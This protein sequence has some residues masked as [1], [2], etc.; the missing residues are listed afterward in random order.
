M[1]NLCLSH[2]YMV[3]VII[4]AYRLCLFVLLNCLLNA[5]G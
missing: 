4:V 2:V 3:S 5:C 1:S